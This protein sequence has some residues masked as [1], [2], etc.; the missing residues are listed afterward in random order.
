[1]I[2][3]PRIEIFDLAT[4]VEGVSQDKALS[5]A[6]ANS[7]NLVSINQVERII[8]KRFLFKKFKDCFP[9]WTCIHVKY[10]GTDCVAIDL[11]TGEKLDCKIPARNGWYKVNKFGLPFGEPSNREDTSARYLWR[12]NSYCGLV[13]RDV[14][15]DFGSGNRNVR[16]G[17][18]GYGYGVLATSIKTHRVEIGKG[19]LNE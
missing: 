12:T 11:S 16:C 19:R 8:N 10:G 7:M 2:E 4:F 13:S 6:K 17:G 5:L 15:D 9:C 14:Y 3:E 18:D 1:M